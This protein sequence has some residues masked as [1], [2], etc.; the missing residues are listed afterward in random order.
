MTRHQEAS[1]GRFP[2][3]RPHRLGASQ[4]SAR[5]SPPRSH[6]EKLRDAFSSATGNNNTIGGRE[7]KCEG[8]PTGGGDVHGDAMVGNTSCFLDLQKK[9]DVADA[10]GRRFFVLQ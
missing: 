6:N 1:D 3:S 5:D 10:G 7:G 8:R 4:D 2:D 9:D